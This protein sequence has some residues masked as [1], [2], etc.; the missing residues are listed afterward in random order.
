MTNVV[1][2]YLIAVNIVAMIFMY[3]CAKTTL[4]KF[5]DSTINF[6][7]VI[8]SILGGSLGILVTSQLIN[9]KRDEKILKKFISLIIFIEVVVILFIL[10]QS[11]K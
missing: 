10:Y 7:L 11:Y 4:I 9:Y 6:I 2:S 3:I 8:I 5:T 1:I